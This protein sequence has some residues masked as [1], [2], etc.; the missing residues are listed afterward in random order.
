M[1]SARITRP[2]K[3]LQPLELVPEQPHVGGIQPANRLRRAVVEVGAVV[4]VIRRVVVPEGLG[5]AEAPTDGRKIV[6]EPLE[7]AYELDSVEVDQARLP[8]QM[9]V[10]RVEIELLDVPEEVR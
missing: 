6:L 9:R 10:A 3:E 2:V 8:T 5:D 1:S 7:S 4:L